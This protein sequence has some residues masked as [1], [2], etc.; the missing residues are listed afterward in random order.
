MAELPSGTVTFLFTDVEGSTRLLKQLRERYG[1]VLAEHRRILRAAFDEHGGQE[2]DTQGDAFFVAFRKATDAALAA[3]AAQRALA[4]HAWPDGVEC[5]VRMGMHTGEP[6]VGDEGYHGLGVHR[7]ARIM[8]AG[9]GGQIL[10]SQATCSVLED[11][12]LPGIS[13]RDL[14]RHRLKDLDRPE[15]I[16]QLDIDGLPS[17]FPP[18]RTAEAPTAYTGHEDELEQAAR[19]VVWRARLRTRRWLAAAIAGFLVAGGLIAVLVLTL[20]SSSAQALSHV[21]SNAVGLIDPKTNR[22][23]D[24]V[25]VGATPSQLAVGEGAEWVINAD[26]DTV[27]RIELAKREAVQTIGVGTAPSGIAV[28]NGAIW[29]AN[30]LD[31]TVS[32]IDPDTNTVVQTIAVGNGPV[33]IAYAAG[34]VWV[35]NTGDDTITR[36]DAGSGK[37]TKTLPIAAAELAFGARTLWAS[38]RTANRVARIDPA[39]GSVVQTIPVGNGPTGLAFGSGAA[40]VANSL[41]GTV[42]RISP[43]SNSITGTIATGNGPT[44]VAIGAGGVW[45]SNQFGGTLARID[46]RTNQVVRR[47]SVGNRPQGV[48]ISNGTVLVSVRLSGAGHRGGTLKVRMNRDVDSI[49]T[50][51]AYDSTSWTILRMT[52]DGLVAFNQAGGLAGTQLVPDVAVSLPTPTNGGRTYTF[53]LR[54]IR[55]SNGKPVRAS[56]FRSTLERD[57]KL[58]T[59]VPLYY[60]GIVGAARCMESTKR[61]DLSHGIV[62]DDTAKTVTFHLSAPDPEFLY[63][64]ALPFAYVVPAG[65]PARPAGTHPLPATGPY[66]IASYRRKHVLT[67][68]RNPYFQ[69]WSQAAQPDGYPNEIVVEIG[70]T[71]D[72]AVNAVIRGKADAFSTAQSETPPSESR[73]AALKTR[74][75]SQVHTNAQPATVYLFLNTRLAPFDRLDVRRALNYAADRAAAVNA[76]GGP[77]VAQATCQVL[78]PH[79]PGYRPYCPYTAGTTTQGR[80]TAPDLDK[81][82]ALIADSGTRGMKITVW[83]WADLPGLGPYMVKLLRSLGYRASLKVRSAPRY[84]EVTSDSRTKAQIGTGEWISDYS[85]ASGFFNPVL[86]CASFRPND[87]GNSNVAEFCDPRIDRQ[88]EQALTEQ[89]TN[90]D[91]ARGLW[92]RIDRQTVD[93]APWVPLV[94]PKVVDVLSKRVGNYQYSPA[95]VGMLIDQLW[96][97]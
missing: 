10:L 6:S 86:T 85:A 17:E 97:R 78:P 37:P 95:G 54:A 22:I 59:P 77:D 73:L 20:G 47:I 93:Q 25:P 89:T 65:T 5:R 27:S 61:C 33:G 39:T 88:I 67:L 60:D 48:A 66:V 2:I 75:A 62:A 44:A 11:D 82:R 58:G 36:I 3:G 40:W 76:V 18:L 41:D 15:H 50:A 68:R 32:R 94:N 16:Y 30:S 35:A 81:A 23:A 56:D 29:V 51:V 70:G 21:D 71:A 42:S 64:L 8:A 4:E 13:V 7:A 34:S 26:D 19:A 46:P 49:D 92:E 90:P 87:P 63:K 28:G 91:A 80:W 38:Q 72:R 69:E 1:Q 9:H 83:S 12:E 24:Q 79:F 43:T 52:G 57:F 45:V 84:W 31:S 14:G 55:Y 74:Y 53:Q 96:V